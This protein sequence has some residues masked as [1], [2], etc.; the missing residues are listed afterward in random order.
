ME[1]GTVLNT[2]SVLPNHVSQPGIW[3]PSAKRGL[4]LLPDLAYLPSW[5]M[6][7]VKLPFSMALAMQK[8]LSKGDGTLD[9]YQVNEEEA[10]RN[11]SMEES[12]AEFPQRQG[13]SG[14]LLLLLQPIK[15]IWHKE[16]YTTRKSSKKNHFSSERSQ[17]TTKSKE[18]MR[19]TDIF[20]IAINRKHYVLCKKS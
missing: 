3:G 1:G 2:I 5:H 7:L 15:H 4:S 12:A 10:K 9:V 18:K 8:P 6:P 17:A 19:H 16:S 14:T 20:C 11:K 13:M